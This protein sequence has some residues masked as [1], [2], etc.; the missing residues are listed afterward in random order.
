MIGNAGPLNIGVFLQAVPGHTSS[1]AGPDQGT[2]EQGTRE[3]GT[4]EQGTREQGTREQG[5][6]EQGTRSRS[7]FHPGSN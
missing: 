6:R 2:R 7:S 1:R 4:R 5:T 3:Q